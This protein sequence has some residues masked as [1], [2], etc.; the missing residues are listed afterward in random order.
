MACKAVTASLASIY[1]LRSDF[2]KAETKTF[3]AGEQG[4]AL[5]P[6]AIHFLSLLGGKK[7]TMLLPFRLEGS[8]TGSMPFTRSLRHT[9]TQ[10]EKPAADYSSSL[11]VPGAGFEA[12]RCLVRNAGCQQK[13]TFAKMVGLITPRWCPQPITAGQHIC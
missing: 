7:M 12:E 11:S 6:K 5:H 9:V 10:L 3:Q 2:P 1:L 13:K 8:P 4:A